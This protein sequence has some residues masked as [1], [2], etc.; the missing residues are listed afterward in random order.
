MERIQVGEKRADLYS[1]LFCNQGHLHPPG[2]AS[3]HWNAKKV[4]RKGVLR[5]SQHQ[6]LPPKYS[7]QILFQSFDAGANNIVCDPNP[8]NQG[9]SRLQRHAV[10]TN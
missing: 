3:N 8:Q 2:S 9:A 4:T 10:Q 7:R 1:F 5:Y 6:N